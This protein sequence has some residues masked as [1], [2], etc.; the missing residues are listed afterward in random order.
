MLLA[1]I[2]QNHLIKA[3]TNSIAQYIYFYL[4][5]TLWIKEI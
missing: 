2:I 1:E 5:M 4:D 3:P